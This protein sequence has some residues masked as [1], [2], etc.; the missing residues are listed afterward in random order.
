MARRKKYTLADLPEEGTVFAV[1]LKNGRMG[2]CRVVRKEM[3]E[4]PYAI[5]AASDWIGDAPPK[6]IDPAVRKILL[7]NHHNW[8]NAP[9]IFWVHELPPENFEAIG[10]IEVL[11]EDR[12]MDAGSYGGWGSA[13]FQILAQWRWDNDR[14]AV[15]AEDAINKSL[16]S[17]KQIEAAQKR[18]EYLSSLSFSKLLAKDLFPSWDDYPPRAAKEG[19][20]KIVKSFIQTLSATREPLGREFVSKELKKCVEQLNQFDSKNKKFICT[21]EREDLCG[22]L[23]DVIN[24]AKFP[25]LIERIEGWRDW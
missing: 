6:L 19:C 8:K 9:E 10:K 14:Q 21:I 15:L 20:Q 1:P 24:A 25:D 7:K 13:P 2:V 3:R 23:E 16:E 4:I 5:V 12:K 22:V 18:E 11:P 17:A